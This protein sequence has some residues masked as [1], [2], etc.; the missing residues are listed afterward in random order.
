MK[1]IIIA[2][3]IAGFIYPEV[4]AQ[5]AKTVVCGSKQEN[6]CRISKDRKTVS[7]YKTGYAENF[8]VCKNNSGYFICCET[9]GYNNS[10]YRGFVIIN[11]SGNYSDPGEMQSKYITWANEKKTADLISPVNQSYINTTLGIK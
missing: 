7:C 10:T 6:V 11:E 5:T 4:K 1:R 8:N 3:T 9:P 2:M